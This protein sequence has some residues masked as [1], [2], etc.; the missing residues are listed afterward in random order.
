MKD[1]YVSICPD[2]DRVFICESGTDNNLCE[3]FAGNDN[4][5]VGDNAA[6]IV[7]CL[8]GFGTALE[9]LRKTACTARM[10]SGDI[11]PHEIDRIDRLID[12]L[13]AV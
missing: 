12:E 2:T 8:N 10:F 6:Y 9:A 13:E 3:V 1:C 4:E 11:L 5:T 7:R